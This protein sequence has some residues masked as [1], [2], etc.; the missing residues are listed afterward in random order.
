MDPILK[1]DRSDMVDPNRMLSMIDNCQRR[2]QSE[3][4][5]HDDPNREIARRDR[6]EDMV[7]KSKV[8][9]QKLI[10]SLSFRGV[11]KMK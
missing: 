8:P 6:E 3:S 5:E 1:Y 10:L 4:T 11:T 2:T 7:Q 9:V